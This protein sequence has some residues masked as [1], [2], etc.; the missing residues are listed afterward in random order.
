MVLRPVVTGGCLALALV[1]ATAPA[2]AQTRIEEMDGV[3]FDDERELDAL[4]QG[5]R[6]PPPRLTWRWRRFSTAEFFVTGIAALTAVGGF[7]PNP[8]RGRWQGGIGFDEDVRDGV[9]LRTYHQRRTA[10]DASDVLVALTVTYPVLADGVVTAGWYH[11]S[12]DVAEQMVLI[13]AEVLA[14]TSAVQS[15]TALVA[16]RE[17]PYGRTCGKELDGDS[18]DCERDDRHRSFFSGHASIS[19]AGASLACI[20]HLH[21]PLYGGGPQDAAVCGVAYATAAATASLRVVGDVHY[22]SDVT[23]G[24]AWGTLAGLGLPWLLHY[25]HPVAERRRSASVQIVPYPGG[26][27]LGGA[28]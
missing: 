17:R 19:F 5:P 27:A 23:I 1:V 4:I 2:R 28:F 26:I 18:R 6:K 22:A 14:V 21:L 20:H 11:D 8:D 13:D 24:A 15:L 3:R 10:R 12:P 16:S 9:R 25:R 7:V